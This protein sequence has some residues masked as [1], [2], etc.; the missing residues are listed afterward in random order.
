MLAKR[1]RMRYLL[2]FLL[3]FTVC[4]ETNAQMP[5]LTI[6]HLTTKEGLSSNDVWCLTKDKQGFLWIGTGRNICRYDGYDFPASG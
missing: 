2:V 1:H 6:D 3:V 4:W 5:T